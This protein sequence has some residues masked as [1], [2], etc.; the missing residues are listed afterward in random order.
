MLAK[1]SASTD[2]SEEVG[3]ESANFLPD[4]AAKAR[5]RESEFDIW[6][7]VAFHDLSNLKFKPLT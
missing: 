5:R 6:A 4:M 3:R 2:A 1:A 7:P